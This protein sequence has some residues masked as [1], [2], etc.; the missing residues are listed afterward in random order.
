MITRVKYNNYFRRRDLIIDG[1]LEIVDG[2]VS[3]LSFGIFHSS[4]SFSWCMF[5]VK[6]EIQ[7]R[8]K[9]V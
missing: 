2:L 3:V 4:F 6:K 7:R 9:G 8:N 5:A 1:L